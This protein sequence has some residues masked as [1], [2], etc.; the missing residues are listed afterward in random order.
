MRKKWVWLL[1]TFFFFFFFSL[2]VWLL[3]RNNEKHFGCVVFGVAWR[4]TFLAR[5]L[6]LWSSNKFCVSSSLAA[7]FENCNMYKFRFIA[8]HHFKAQII[9]ICLTQYKFF[10]LSLFCCCSSKL[11]TRRACVLA[12]SC[13]FVW[14]R[15]YY[16]RLLQLLALLLFSFL[17]SL[18]LSLSIWVV[19]FFLLLLLFIHKVKFIMI[20]ASRC[21]AA[22]WATNESKT[23]IFLPQ[24]THV[25]RL[26]LFSYF[27]ISKLEEICLTSNMLNRN[28]TISFLLLSILNYILFV[29]VLICVIQSGCFLCSC[30]WERERERETNTSHWQT[31]KWL[32]LIR[33]LHSRSQS[34]RMRACIWI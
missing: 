27:S 9:I 10:S 20:S 4:S 17:L 7:T 1:F 25:A 8:T 28:K 6:V 2:P 16:K 14:A 5:W 24:A 30:Q 29:L 31:E 19:C 21:F 13:S 18:S 26:F 22:Q 34:L 33:V 15:L 32:K 23:K 12:F 3:M 11:W